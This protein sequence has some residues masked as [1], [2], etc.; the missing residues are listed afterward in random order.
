MDTRRL[1]E[2]K[3]DPLPAVWF[4]DYELPNEVFVFA[5]SKQPHGLH[6][7]ITDVLSDRHKIIALHNCNVRLD[8]ATHTYYRRLTEGGGEIAIPSSVT[9]I[10]ELYA[11][12][13][14]K[15]EVASKIARTGVNPRYR[16]S[17]GTMMDARSIEALWDANAAQACARGVLFHA[18]AEA[19]LN[20]QYSPGPS[21]RISPEFC[22]FL[23]YMETLQRRGWQPY[24]TEL[25]LWHKA[26]N[27][28]GQVD[29][30]FQDANGEYHM[31][32]W[33]RSKEICTAGFQGRNMK[34][35]LHDLADCNLDHYG[36][37]Q[38]L[39]REILKRYYEDS[40]GKPIV[41]KTMALCVCHPNLIEQGH[42]YRE[43]RI[44]DMQAEVDVMLRDYV[45][46]FE[47]SASRSKSNDVAPSQG[48]HGGDERSQ[49]GQSALQEG[50]K[51]PE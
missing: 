7:P 50:T 6:G 48:A 25:S 46:M 13:F 49:R 37:Q 45:G 2:D 36:L 22:Q 29:A 40:T 27:F 41:V 24:R 42:T 51:S 47:A 16:W 1:R 21:D 3:E 10:V 33:K 19:Y 20:D 8:T 23:K 34:R 28:G 39:Y 35:P 38:N 4:L 15:T 31:V 14:D 43:Y 30:L 12:R 5:S 18:Q 9:E 44:R 11:E 17:D 26:C 32:D